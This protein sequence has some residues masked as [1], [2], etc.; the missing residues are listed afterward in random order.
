DGGIE[1]MVGAA[2]DELGVIIQQDTD[3]LLQ[4]KFAGKNCRGLLDDGHGVFSFTVRSPKLSVPGGK[5]RKHR[6]RCRG[7]E[8]PQELFGRLKAQKVGSLPPDLDLFSP[9]I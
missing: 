6:T 4:L 8:R 2:F 1:N 3:G 5:N 7:R 9:G